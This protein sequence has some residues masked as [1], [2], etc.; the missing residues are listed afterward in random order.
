MQPISFR[1]MLRIT[2]KYGTATFFNPQ[3]VIKIENGF[4]NN[5][6]II[7]TPTSNSNDLIYSEY[8]VNCSAEK[9]VNALHEAQQTTDKAY[10]DLVV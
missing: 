10:I 6:S 4:S 8:K 9:L 5:K 1:A 2:D 3:Q 7:H